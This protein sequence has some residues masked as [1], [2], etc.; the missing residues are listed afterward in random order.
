MQVQAFSKLPYLVWVICIAG[1]G[2]KT[3]IQMKTN[4]NNELV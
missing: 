1:L 4:Q 3:N 2:L